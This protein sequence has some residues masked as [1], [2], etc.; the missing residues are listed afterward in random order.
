MPRYFVGAIRVEPEHDAGDVVFIPHVLE[1]HGRAAI[2]HAGA[3]AHDAAAG[4]DIIVDA[5]VGADRGDD[6]RGPTGHA[7]DLVDGVTDERLGVTRDG[8]RWIAGVDRGGTIDLRQVH[9]SDRSRDR[10]KGRGDPWLDLDQRGIAPSTEQAGGA[11][12]AGHEVGI[13]DDAAN[14]VRA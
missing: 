1:H 11:G 12:T 5:H 7:P 8:E 4:P 14:K 6:A 13:N 2:A 9:A 3:G 10:T